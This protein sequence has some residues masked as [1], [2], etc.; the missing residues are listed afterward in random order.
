MYLCISPLNLQYSKEY[1]IPSFRYIDNSV[2]VHECSP[3]WVGIFITFNIENYH[4]YCF[5]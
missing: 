5:M 4:I 3:F 1:P 2:N